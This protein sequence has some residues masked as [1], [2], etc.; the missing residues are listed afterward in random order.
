MS[1]DQQFSEDLN[2]KYSKF[3]KSRTKP[4]SDIVKTFDASKAGLVHAIMGLSGEVGELLNP[5]KNVLVPNKELDMDNIVEELGD[6]EFYL[7]MLRQELDL[8]REF[9][10]VKN[11][12]KLEKRYPTKYTDKDA[13]ERKDKVGE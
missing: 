7:E 1:T 6:I 9:I 3:V 2:D 11:I 12:S 4:P 10:L 5:I 13:L 8:T